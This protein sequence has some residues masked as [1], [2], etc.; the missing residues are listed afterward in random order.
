MLPSNTLYEE[1]GDKG[2]LQWYV[3]HDDLRCASTM[4]EG[5]SLTA[6]TSSLRYMEQAKGSSQQRPGAIVFPAFLAYDAYKKDDTLVE[7]EVVAD[8]MVK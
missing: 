8:K 4:H 7:A 3:P 5:M 2:K 6:P 1:L